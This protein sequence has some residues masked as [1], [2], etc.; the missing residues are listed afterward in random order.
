MP[1]SLSTG[2]RKSTMVTNEVSGNVRCG[3]MWSLRKDGTIRDH[4]CT[5]I[6]GAVAQQPFGSAHLPVM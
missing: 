3:Q 1:R 6:V 4:S 2:L 5:P